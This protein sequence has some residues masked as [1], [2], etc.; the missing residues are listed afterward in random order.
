[1][2]S[3]AVVSRA[4]SVLRASPPLLALGLDWRGEPHRVEGRLFDV[5]CVL[6]VLCGVRVCPV[7]RRQCWFSPARRESGE[8]VGKGKREGDEERKMYE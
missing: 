8:G 7:L 2:E 4:H 5:C 3:A 1:M 6:R